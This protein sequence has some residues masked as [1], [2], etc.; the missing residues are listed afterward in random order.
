MDI[1]LTA[2]LIGSTIASE[3][4]LRE[5]DGRKRKDAN[6]LKRGGTHVPREP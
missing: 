2:I 6:I 4:P 1:H 5:P 3:D